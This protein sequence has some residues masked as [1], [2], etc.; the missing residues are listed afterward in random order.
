MSSVRQHSRGLLD[1]A[2]RE[3]TPDAAT[4]ERV[5]KS[6]TS[7]TGESD[8]LASTGP[9]DERNVTGAMK[10]LVLAAVALGVALAVYL[11]GHTRA[12]PEP[13]RQSPASHRR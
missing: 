7:T 4:R 13:S 1:A 3:C 5:F 8:P 10:W 9:I 12:A 2:R 6:L 11:A